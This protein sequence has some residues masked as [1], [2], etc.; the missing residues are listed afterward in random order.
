MMQKKNTKSLT[1]LLSALFFSAA[2]C[3]VFTH[4]ADAKGAAVLQPSDCIKCHSKEPRSIEENGKKHQTDVTCL[5]CHVEHPP[6]G[7][8]AIPACSMCH[9]GEAHYQLENCMGC[10]SDPHQPLNL[11]IAGD[12]T[13]PCLT[14]HEDQGF[15][16]QDNPSKH[17]D[18]SCT[19][20]HNVHGLIPDCS[21]CHEPHVAGQTTPECLACH[22][23][24]SPLTIEYP[25]TTPRPY[26][27]ACHEEVGE[28]MEK[29]RTKH[30]TFTCAF[31]HR[32]EH[33]NVPLCRTCHGEPHS[34]TTHKKMPGCLE[35]HLDAHN[36]VK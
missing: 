34:Q 4:N 22:P 29:T 36:L 11:Q 6:E 30:Q 31:C 24:H 2:M 5:D 16:M 26:C 12:I 28:L 35:C 3:I 18:V 21:K 27:T 7:T 25:M 10:H 14:C 19:F 20:C 23:V 17:T 1:G 9:S 8:N 13:G 33:P 32:G 15:E